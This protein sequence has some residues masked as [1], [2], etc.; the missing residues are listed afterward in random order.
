MVQGILEESHR[1]AVMIRHCAR[2]CLC[3][4]TVYVCGWMPRGGLLFQTGC[5]MMVLIQLNDED[6]DDGVEEDGGDYLGSKV[7]QRCVM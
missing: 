2:K 5:K 6:E 7:C 3:V 1:A 4:C